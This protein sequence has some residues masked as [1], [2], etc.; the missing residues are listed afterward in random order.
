MGRTTTRPTTAWA[1]PYNHGMRNLA[2]IGAALLFLAPLVAQAP[3][4]LTTVDA[5]MQ[6]PSYY[7]LQPVVVRGTVARTASRVTLRTEAHELRL[8]LETAHS[9]ELPEVLALPVVDGSPNY[10][11]WMEGELHP[12]EAA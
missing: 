8:L 6:F 10:L 7:H 4:R 3:V 5:L 11:A 9:Y 2:G 1:R 12:P